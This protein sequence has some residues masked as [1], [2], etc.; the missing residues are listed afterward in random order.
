MFIF[1]SPLIFIPSFPHVV[2]CHI[3]FSVLYN[4]FDHPNFLS[5]QLCLQFADCVLH[6][7]KTPSCSCAA[8]CVCLYL[9]LCHSHS[10]ILANCPYLILIGTVPILTQEKVG[11]RSNFTTCPYLFRN[12]PIF[13]DFSP[14]C[15]YFLGFRVGKY[16]V[17]KCAM[18][19]FS[20]E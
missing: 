17:V 18:L 9:C 7:M 13:E 10:C 15:P 5:Q 8:L 19:V 1:M 14:I 16:V 4:L 12:V 2:F 6:N 3:S 20:Q 11:K